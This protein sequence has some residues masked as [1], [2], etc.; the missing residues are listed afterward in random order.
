[1][2]L[3]Q[4]GEKKQ[5]WGKKT[6]Q[7]DGYVYDTDGGMMMVSCISISKHTNLYTLSTALVYQAYLDK[8]FFCLFVFFKEERKG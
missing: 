4:K 3:P 8:A 5:S 6:F 2:L 7:G 1:M